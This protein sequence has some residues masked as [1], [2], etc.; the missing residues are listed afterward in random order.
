M[1]PKNQEESDQTSKAQNGRHDSSRNKELPG[2]VPLKGKEGKPKGDGT[3]RGKNRSSVK[4][5]VGD[6]EDGNEQDQRWTYAP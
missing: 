4:P 5:D 2:L 1:V 6:R 3:E